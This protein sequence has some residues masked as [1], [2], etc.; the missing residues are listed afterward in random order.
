MDLGDDE[1]R[2]CQDSDRALQVPKG[3][4]QYAL[5]EAVFADCQQG[6]IEGPHCFQDQCGS[7]D[8]QVLAASFQGGVLQTLFKG[9]RFQVLEQALYVFQR[10]VE[11]MDLL[12]VVGIYIAVHRR[13]GGYGSSGANQHVRNRF[14]QAEKDPVQLLPDMV[15]QIF[16]FPGVYWMLRD[17]LFGEAHDPE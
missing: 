4:E 6:T 10:K 9:F 17:E 14:A 13:Q 15:L 2:D 5:A 7:G 12:G 3:L 16:I 11:S 1:F 8:D